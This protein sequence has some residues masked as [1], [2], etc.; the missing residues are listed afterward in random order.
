MG[1]IVA[2][3]YELI[4]AI[5]RG[6]TGTVWRAED[7]A[8]REAF[9]VKLLDAQFAND[10]TVVERF[11]RERHALSALAHPALVRV[12]DLVADGMDLALV[13]DLVLGLDMR[14]EIGMSGGF[15]PD[16]A[17]QLC[18]HA[19]EA[20]AAAHAAGLVH[21]DIKP[22]NL[23]LTEARNVTEAGEL[24]GARVL[25]IT[26][27][28]VAWL[29]RGHR[30]GVSRFGSPEYAVPEVILGSPPVPA[31]DVYG[32]GL[33]LYEALLGV[34]LFFDDDPSHVLRQ[35][36]R[37]RPVVPLDVPAPLRDVVESALAREPQ[38][39]P[40]ADEFADDLRRLLS[41]QRRRTATPAP[42]PPVVERP[43]QHSAASAPPSGGGRR[44]NRAVAAISSRRRPLV[45]GAVV[46]LIAVLTGLILASLPDARGSAGG[47]G[48][49]PSG[50][51]TNQHTGWPAPQLSAEASAATA[52]G[53][54]IFTRYWFDALNYAVATGDTGPLSAA[55]NPDC[56]T[57]A[58]ILAAI[59]RGYGNGAH[60]Q[61]GEYTLRQATADNFFTLTQP[62]LGIVYD[63][64]PYSVVASSGAQLESSPG[65]T[66]ATCQVLLERVADHWRLREIFGSTPVA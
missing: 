21:G 54:A 25:R 42:P 34:P 57:C 19:A 37:G 61:G 8:T 27:C 48:A 14:Q 20:L 40:R 58:A 15:P 56:H 1:R 22:A 30:D 5:G 53:A 3:Q 52:D 33:V 2:E 16:I 62:K 39:R 50:G 11:V 55:T 28:R 36:L 64:R 6:P 47:A 43:A 60:L 32:L 4:G 13:G 41:A 66:F 51:A 65:V 45:I 18:L 49:L 26:D 59:N 63:R 10:A 46:A 38:A 17:V 35:H 12:G 44:P 29:A 31:T 23:L 9:A 24:A 7:R